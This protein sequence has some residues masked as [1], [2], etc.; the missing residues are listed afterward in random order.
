MVCPERHGTKYASGNRA[1]DQA[2]S[3]AIGRA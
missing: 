3:P 2:Q 1:M